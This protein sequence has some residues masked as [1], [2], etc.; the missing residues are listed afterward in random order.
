VVSG[1]AA[2]LVGPLIAKET[3]ANKSMPKLNRTERRQK[4]KEIRTQAAEIAYLRQ[5]Q[6][7]TP[8]VDEAK[9]ATLKYTAFGNYSKGLKHIAVTDSKNPGL[10][11]PDKYRDFV[12]ALNTGDSDAFNDIPTNSLFNPS[13]NYRKLTDPQA[14]LG[15]DLQGPDAQ[16]HGLPPAPAIGSAQV[17]AEMAE[18]YWMALLRDTPFDN[19]DNEN[20]AKEAAKDLSKYP[21]FTAGGPGGEITTE[22]LFR[23]TSFGLRSGNYISQFLLIGNKED[24]LGLK[25]DSSAGLLKYGAFELSQMQKCALP[26]MDYMTDPD[27]W[28]AVQDGDASVVGKDQFE[29]HRHF[30]TTPRDMATFVHFDAL[31]EAYLNAC[32]YLVNSGAPLSAGNPY[33]GSPNQD[34]FGTFGSPHIL[35]LVTEVATRALKCVWYQKW[36]VH[37]RLRPETYGGRVHFHLANKIG[38]KNRE[39]F[40]SKEGGTEFIHPSLLDDLEKGGLA[41]YFGQAAADSAKR[42]FNNYFLPMAFPEGSPT[43]PSY[44]AGHA[45]VAAACVTVL[46][47]FFDENAKFENPV[48]VDLSDP[49]HQKLVFAKPADQARWNL[50]IGGELNKLAANV[51]IGRNMAGVHYWSDDFESRKLGEQIGIEILQEQSLTYNEQR[52]TGG[53]IYFAFTRMDGKTVVTIA[54]GEIMESPIGG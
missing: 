12:K 22:T 32:W 36:Q 18:L 21:F 38:G 26:N 49:L 1:N 29:N 37:R 16:E 11:E 53:E 48:Q 23:S 46:K 47:A 28:L 42:L 35:S 17:A 34:G 51:S 40:G 39:L 2:Y 25:H 41:S 52:A 5:H 4:A 6:V 19:F 8:N 7:Q 24:A 33:V 31:Y 45:T 44:G 30:I 9:F 10:V 15:F 14:G 20:L 27:S 3:T 43:H 54:N 50:T 13:G